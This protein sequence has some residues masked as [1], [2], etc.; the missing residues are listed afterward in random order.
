MIL[1]LYDEHGAARVPATTLNGI[2]AFVLYDPRKRTLPD[3]ARSDRRH[4][5]STSGRDARRATCYVASEMKALVGPCDR[6]RRV[7][8]GALLDS[9]EA[10][11]A[12]SATTS[13]PGASPRRAADAARTTRPCCATALEAAVHRQL[14]C[15]VP[16]G[17]LLSGGLDS[18]VIAAVR[19]AVRAA[20]GRGGRPRRR[21]VAAAAL[22]R[23][24]ARGRSGPGAARIGGRPHRHRA[25]RAALH[26]AGGPR[27]ALRR[28]PSPR[29]LRRHDDPRVDA[30]VPAWRARS[31]RWASRWCSRAKAPTRSS[32]ATSTSTRRRDGRAFHEETVR[33]LAEAAPLR[34]PAREQVD[35]RLGRRGARARSSTASSSTWR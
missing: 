24:R 7:P 29:D 1:A 19:R 28:D 34:L 25:P 3:R 23:D 16:Y 6:I 4:T 26:R 20:A 21:L 13:R 2:F 17:V 14:M 32:A 30:D 15:D 18:S 22:V 12:S 27:R 9:D 11:R 31:A 10:A 33:K 8:A 35:G 5:R